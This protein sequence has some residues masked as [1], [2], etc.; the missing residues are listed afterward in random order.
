MRV[1]VRTIR[2]ALADSAAP[3]GGALLAASETPPDV[4]TRQV[5]RFLAPMRTGYVTLDGAGGA[6][7][8]W[9]RDTH[10][11]WTLLEHGLSEPFCG[12]ALDA[13]PH[14]TYPE[15]YARLFFSDE[16]LPYR[17]SDARPQMIPAGTAVDLGLVVSGG[18]LHTDPTTNTGFVASG[19]P[20]TTRWIT[21]DGARGTSG[22]WV[23]DGESIRLARHGVPLLVRGAPMLLPWAGDRT[24]I[25]HL[26]ATDNPLELPP[27]TERAIT[28]TFN[29]PSVAAL[30]ECLFVEFHPS[31]SSPVVTA[32]ADSDPGDTCVLDIDAVDDAGSGD[33]PDATDI[34]TQALAAGVN[35]HKTFTQANSTLLAFRYTW[36]EVP[37]DPGPPVVPAPP[38]PV[39][40]V[41]FAQAVGR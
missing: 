12:P 14:A 31:L 15:Q 28:Y 34:T 23:Y 11:T 39:V 17:L 25:A 30:Q 40:T 6:R 1:E 33:P 21:L 5:L 37:E 8:L 4:N 19:L 36:T 41:R 26:Y 32:Y 20:A 35:A 38:A 13:V 29:G 9:L 2:P 3:S 7:R 22:V 16:A 24:S 27:V 10:G 18:V